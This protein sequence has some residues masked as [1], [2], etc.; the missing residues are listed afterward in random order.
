MKSKT[1]PARGPAAAAREQAHERAQL[2]AANRLLKK[3]MKLFAPP[4]P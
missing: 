4:P 3:V 1:K 2:A